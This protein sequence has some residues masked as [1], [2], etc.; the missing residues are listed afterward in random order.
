MHRA[1][2]ERERQARLIDFAISGWS[3]RTDRQ[4]APG[5]TMNPTYEIV[6]ENRSSDPIRNV[7]VRVEGARNS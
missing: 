5:I 4:N 7:E 2:E 6:I 1:R 3:G